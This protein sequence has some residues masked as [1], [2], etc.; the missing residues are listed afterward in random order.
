MWRS[1]VAERVVDTPFSHVKYSTPPKA[2]QGVRFGLTDVG[3][4][5]TGLHAG[6]G[7]DPDCDDAGST[8]PTAAS[9]RTLAGIQE[10]W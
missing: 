6:L 8:T 7:L 5:G 4:A 1:T 9:A 2:C 10:D 3:L